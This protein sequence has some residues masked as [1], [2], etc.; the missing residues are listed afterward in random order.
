[1][2][3]SGGEEWAFRAKKNARLPRDGSKFETEPRSPGEKVSEFG[4]EEARMVEQESVRHSLMSPGAVRVGRP[5]QRKLMSQN[6]HHHRVSMV[7]SIVAPNTGGR[8]TS[9]RGM[10]QRI[11][12]EEKRSKKSFSLELR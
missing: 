7:K 12:E 1:M 8:D 6:F 2:F 5:R 4:K 10:K 9:R 11:E 3:F